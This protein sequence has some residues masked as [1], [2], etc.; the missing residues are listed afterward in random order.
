MSMEAAFN[1][2]TSKSQSSL[3][4]TYGTYFL[5]WI[6]DFTNQGRRMYLIVQNTAFPTMQVIVLG[7]LYS[8]SCM[9]W[10]S[11]FWTS[12][13]C[14]TLGS[15]WDIKL[16]KIDPYIPGIWNLLNIHIRRN[17]IVASNKGVFVVRRKILMIWKRESVNLLIFCS[18]YYKE[19]LLFCN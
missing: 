3:F 12:T 4:V 18:K 15:I 5:P 9:Y 16:L 1:Y 17:M 7:M 10:I 8:D 19:Q 6:N 11:V 13:L 14:Q 2:D